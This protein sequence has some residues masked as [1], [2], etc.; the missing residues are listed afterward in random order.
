MI[1][2]VVVSIDGN[3]YHVPNEITVTQYAEVMRRIN[4]TDD[5][6]EK[7][8]DIINVIMDIPYP[9]IRELDPEH[10]AD[11][12]VYLQEK[13]QESNLKLIPFFKFKGVE[14]GTLN[15]TKM[16]FGE[17]IDLVNYMKNENNLYINIYK[18]CAILYRPIVEKSK[19]KYIIKPYNIEEHE[20][21][22]EIFKDLPVK[23][24]FGSFY[25]LYTYFNQLKKDFEVLFGEDKM[26]LPKPNDKEIEEEQSNLPW[27]KMI[28]TLTNEDFTKID[29]VTSRPVVECFN[30][31]SYITIKNEELRQK[32]LEHQNKMKLF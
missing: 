15:L 7:A 30:H 8:Y 18:I 2:K 5:I 27:Y 20:E 13:I 24:F 29:Y 28:M 12:S 14:Y 3:D 22:S 11:L 31:L 21:L 9:L 1:K 32:Q 16:T 23:Y 4:L 10:V 25:N 19:T 26:D 17:Y 6:M